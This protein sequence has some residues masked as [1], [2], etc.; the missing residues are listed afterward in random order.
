MEPTLKDQTNQKLIQSGVEIMDPASTFIDSSVSIAPGVKIYPNNV[1]EGNTTIGEGTIIYPSC[2]I[3]NGTIGANITIRQSVITDSTVHDNATVGPFA[4]LRE[5]AVIGP[6]SRIGNFVEVKNATLAQGVKAA[7]LAY[8][9]DADVGKNV[10]YSCG[11]I[12]S[13]YDGKKKHRTTIGDNA[14]IG[15]NSNLIAPVTI[16]ENVLVA[17][18]STITDDLKDNSLGIARARQVEKLNWVKK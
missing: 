12:T 1:I 3:T 7:H 4:Y 10:N 6:G 11:V 16:G 8:I 17:A 2:H 13:N 5:H 9:G 15:S 14:F 18:G